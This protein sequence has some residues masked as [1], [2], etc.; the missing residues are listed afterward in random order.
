[1]VEEKSRIKMKTK[2]LTVDDAQVEMIKDTKVRQFGL[3]VF[4]MSLFLTGSDAGAV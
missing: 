2:L 3:E 4:G 1:M